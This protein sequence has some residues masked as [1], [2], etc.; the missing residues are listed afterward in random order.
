[1]RET[2]LLLAQLQAF[3]KHGVVFAAVIENEVVELVLFRWPFHI[4]SDPIADFTIGNGS[5]DDL[6]EL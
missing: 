4:R 1:M 6:D 5:S 2:R 3:A